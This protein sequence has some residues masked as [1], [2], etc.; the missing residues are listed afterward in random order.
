MFPLIAQSFPVAKIYGPRTH[1]VVDFNSSLGNEFVWSVW[2]QTHVSYQTGFPFSVLTSVLFIVFCALFVAENRRYQNQDGSY[3]SYASGE[4]TQSSQID[5]RGQY[6]EWDSYDAHAT[7]GYDHGY[8]WRFPSAPWHCFF[9]ILIHFVCCDAPWRFFAS[10]AAKLCLYFAPTKG[11]LYTP[12]CIA[13]SPGVP[14]RDG[15]FK[16][17]SDVER[18]G[19]G[20]NRAQLVPVASPIPYPWQNYREHERKTTKLQ[21][22]QRSEV[23]MWC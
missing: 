19:K 14:G 9:S 22:F 11:R 7:G 21:T 5:G 16:K 15:K 17:V 2:I 20:L 10:N 13:V 23:G 4:Y 12:S 3:S 8:S 6:R 18:V 1:T